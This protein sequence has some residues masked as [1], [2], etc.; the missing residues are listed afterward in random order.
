MEVKDLNNKII[1]IKDGTKNSLLELI[2]S[3][4]KL[5]N[6]KIITL[7]ELKKKYYFDY[8]KETI[9]YIVKNYNV[10]MS[11]AKKY[12]ENLYYINND[13]NN[14]FEKVKFLYDLKCDL[15]NNNLIEENELFK[16]FLTNKNIVLYNLKYVDKFYKNIFDELRKNNNVEEINYEHESSIK[17]LYTASSYEEEISFVASKICELIKSGV[18]IN[19]IKLSNVKK[20][21]SYI[22]NKTFKMFNIP[23]TLPSFTTIKGTNIVKK[24]KELYESDIESTI[25]EVKKLVKT[26]NDKKVFK[27]LINILNSYS[28][29]NYDNVKELIFEELDNI[30]TESVKYKNS[31]KVVDITSEIINDNDYVFLINFNE[32]VIP[33]NYKDED[34]LNDKIKE[35]LNISISSELNKNANL[36]LKES[37][38]KIK[39]LIVTYSKYD[40]NNEIFISPAYD[41]KLF[42]N[43]DINTNFNNSNLYNKI[44]LVSDMDELSKYGVISNE[45][46]LL[47][48]HYKDIKYLEY[49]NKFKGIDIKSLHE[50]LSKGLTLSYTSI[51]SYYE[52]SFKYYLNYILRLNK[53]EDNFSTVI[54]NIFHEI[55]SYAFN[56]GFDFESMWKEVV[57]KT[58]ITYSFNN[59]EKFFL[60]NLKE[61]LILIIDTIKEQLKYTSLKKSMYEKEVKIEI[62]KDLNIIFT[63]KIDKV[64][65][66]E[67][68]GKTICA[69]IDYKTGST[70]MDLKYIPFGL[71]MQLPVYIYLLKNSNIIDN[72][73]VGG[74]YLQ[75]IISSDR[76]INTRISNLKLQGYTNSDESIIEKVDSSYV[77]SKIIKNLRLTNNGFYKHSKLLSEEEIDDLSILV[78]NKI[79]EASNNIINGKFD[80]NPKCIKSNNIGCTYCKFKDICYMKYEDTVK[81]N[82]ESEVEEDA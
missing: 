69:I 74:F 76:N 64:L 18:N 22:I 63:G 45:L 2:N 36:E 16:S 78:G 46:I 55:L 72:V 14:N 54:G 23:V 21:Y 41:E 25:R 56:D 43:K 12:I 3:Y 34:Y 28:F 61:E 9:Y 57:E 47:S 20:E 52:C 33:I 77:D 82:I 67:F 53:Y 68:D 49:D 39:N 15:L 48:N 1:I 17:E 10:N 80:I 31:V 44:K 38:S 59:M 13:N 27:Q 73:K 65:Y 81:L 40:T 19:N 26:S 32:G 42:I 75:K 6:I 62:N 70:S 11:I 37:I 50:Y 35:K 30:Q 79:K 29:E 66:D 8:N 24:F 60:N 4:G 5:M 71:K 51:N 58:S 7:N